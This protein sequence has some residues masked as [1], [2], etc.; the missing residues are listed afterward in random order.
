MVEISEKIKDK[1]ILLFLALPVLLYFTGDYVSATTI[2]P[3]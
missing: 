3:M 1:Y 2:R